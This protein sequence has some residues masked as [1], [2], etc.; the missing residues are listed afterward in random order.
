[1]ITT[2]QAYNAY[3]AA[4]KKAGV[5]PALIGT[6]KNKAGI[7]EATKKLPKIPPVMAKTVKAAGGKEPVKAALNGSKPAKKAAAPTKKTAAT[8]TKASATNGESYKVSGKTAVLSQKLDKPQRAL[9]RR[10]YEHLGKERPGR[11]TGATLPVELIA[12]LGY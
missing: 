6:L 11:W 8:P 9:A 2:Q 5:K 4:A 3:V 7:T 1:M 10:W 12:A